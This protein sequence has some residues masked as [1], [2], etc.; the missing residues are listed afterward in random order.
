MYQHVL[1]SVVSA[2]AGPPDA[3]ASETVASS[4]QVV[5]TKPVT[6]TVTSPMPPSHFGHLNCRCLWKQNV[7]AAV[8]GEAAAAT[9]IFLHPDQVS[10]GIPV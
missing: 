10:V 1:P 7:F 3:D 9:D 6:E 8:V 2:A 4:V 5:K